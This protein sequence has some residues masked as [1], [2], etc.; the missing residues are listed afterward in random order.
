MSSQQ[1]FAV[2]RFPDRVEVVVTGR[3]TADASRLFE[4]GEADR[5]V[6]NYAHGF[7]ETDLEFLRGLPV[8]QLVVLD[9]RLGSLAPLSD[10]GDTLE[11]LHVT[12]APSLTID[13]GRFPR[14]TDLSADWHQ[15]VATIKAASNLERLHVGRYDQVD[16]EPLAEFAGL[17]GSR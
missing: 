4:S 6:L 10:L 7:G 16:L 11:L 9:R 14:L 2:G 15:V 5:L 8:R 3:W 12:T 13:L 1:E 17:L